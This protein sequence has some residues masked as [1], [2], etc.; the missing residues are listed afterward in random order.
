MQTSVLGNGGEIFVLDMGEAI[1]IRYLAEQMIRLSGKVPDEEI[2]IE[3]VGL[4]PGEKLYEELFHEMEQLEP[5]QHNKVLLARHRPVDWD[6]LS[7]IVEEM[8]QACFKMDDT[9]LTTLLRELV[10]EH[11][12]QQD[13]TNSAEVVYLR[14][15]TT[16]K[17]KS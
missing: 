6:R 5:T 16:Q 4:R 17:G 13:K 3:Y 15:Q 9:A 12:V 10:P 1:K 8:E 2:M 14:K 11:G 7:Q